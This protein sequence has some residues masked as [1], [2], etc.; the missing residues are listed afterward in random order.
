MNGQDFIVSEIRERVG[1]A[2]VLISDLNR[3]VPPILLTV[4][5]IAVN[6]IKFGDVC[7]FKH[8]SLLWCIVSDPHRTPTIQI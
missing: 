2:C 3:V 4:E 8:V 1:G 5:C 6:K 7:S